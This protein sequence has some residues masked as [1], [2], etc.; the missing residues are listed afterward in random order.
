VPS[1]QLRVQDAL[2]LIFRALVDAAHG[3]E[4]ACFTPAAQ[5]A[6]LF[7]TSEAL[8]QRDRNLLAL[9]LLGWTASGA[10]RG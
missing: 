5:D 2:L 3:I 10:A 1:S 6:E 4:D 9:L 8:Q 7:R